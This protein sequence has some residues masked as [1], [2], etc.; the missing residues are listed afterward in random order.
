MQNKSQKWMGIGFPSKIS[1]FIVFNYFSLSHWKVFVKKNLLM[2]DLGCTCA[3]GRPSARN[4]DQ[5]RPGKQLIDQRRPSSRGEPIG[6]GAELDLDAA[7]PCVNKTTD[8][9][10]TTIFSWWAHWL[11]SGAGSG[12]HTTLRK[13]NSWLINDDHLLMVSP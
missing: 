12:C 1:S 6:W 13:Q 8:W 2:F 3:C 10:M 7:L 4:R 9:S 5:Y 11:G